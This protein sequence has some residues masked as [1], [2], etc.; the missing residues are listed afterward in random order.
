[1]LDYEYQKLL[2][3][4]LQAKK[5]VDNQ[6]EEVL[7]NIKNERDFIDLM[8]YISSNRLLTS[9]DIYSKFSKIQARKKAIRKNVV[10]KK[11][12]IEE[13]KIKMNDLFIRKI[14][15]DWNLISRN[16]YVRD[17]DAIHNLTTLDFY[18]PITFFVGEN[19]SGKSTLLEAIAVA[20]GFNPEGGSRNFC[21][22][23]YDS[24]SELSEAVKLARG[25]RKVQWSYF[26]RA[27]SFYNVATNVEKLNEEPFGGPKLESI[28]NKSHGEGFLAMAENN[29]KPNGLYI[30]DE[31]EAALSPQRQLTFLMKIAEMAN[32]GCQFIIVSH[33]PILLAI[34]DAEILSFDEGKLHSIEYEKT[35]SYQITE[36]FI[37]NRERILKQLLD[38]NE[39]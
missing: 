31:P 17:I 19:G 36:L 22:S 37:N 39:V 29:F 4:C 27:E 2:R 7:A 33:S 18:S 11:K 32:Q 38:R 35:E 13:S 1:M 34:P 9:E 20:Y 6:I 25:A 21:F 15:I 12:R 28:H 14:N 10:D 30:L 8:N 16:S 5:M 26:L 3:G 23:T 24:H